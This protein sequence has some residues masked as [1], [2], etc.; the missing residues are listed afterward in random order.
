MSETKESTIDQLRLMVLEACH[1]TPLL[2]SRL[3]KAAF[4]VLMRPVLRVGEKQYR[5]GSEDGLRY[6]EVNNGRC[7]CSDYIR[8]GE[9]HWCKHRL[10]LGLLVALEGKSRPP[11]TDE[12]GA[13][14]FQI[15]YSS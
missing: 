6:Y 8:H 9:G 5:I 11:G 1:A 2:T 12:V 14:N 13:N 4:L 10:A 15:S 3:E 7:E